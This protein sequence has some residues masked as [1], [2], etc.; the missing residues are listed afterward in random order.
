MESLLREPLKTPS[1]T[2]GLLQVR[3]CELITSAA[4]TSRYYTSGRAVSQKD[5]DQYT[6]LIP[7]H[8]LF[9]RF[10]DSGRAIT[11]SDTKSSGI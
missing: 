9:G 5:I 10:E 8:E 6:L 11:V 7:K 1:A 3:T 4:K 2:V